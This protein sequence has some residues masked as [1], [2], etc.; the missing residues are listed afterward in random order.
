ME[1][2]KK[3]EMLAEEYLDLWISHVSKQN[4]MPWDGENITSP[5]LQGLY[6]QWEDFYHKLIDPSQ[7]SP[8]QLSPDRIFGGLAP[9]A[10]QEGKV[11]Y[12]EEGRP[13]NQSS[14]SPVSHDVSSDELAELKARLGALA[15]QISELEAKNRDSGK[16][17][18]GD[19]RKTKR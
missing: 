1:E 19:I 10:S 6:R 16:N 11:K 7:F 12:D 17:D 14:S 2:E 5:E 3:L 13:Q 4:L 8:N 18:A 9:T 15:K